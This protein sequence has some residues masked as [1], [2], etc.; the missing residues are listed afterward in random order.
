MAILDVSC[1]Y[2]TIRNTSGKRKKFGFL[3]PHGKELAANEEFT[4][5][6]DI[7]QAL[8]KF[9][10]SEA[11]RSITAFE[12][13]LRRGDIEIIATPNIILEDLQDPGTT[14]M[15]TLR[16]GTLGVADPCWNVSSSISEPY[17]G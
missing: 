17:D 7:R 11:R 6:G 1:L 10:R 12:A 8:I 2:S 9:E 14:K 4:C 13:A 16:N 5:F 15:L 3:P